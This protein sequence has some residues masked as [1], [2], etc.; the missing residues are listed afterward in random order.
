MIFPLFLYS[1]YPS[2]QESIISP[3]RGE[4]VLG[5]TFVTSVKTTKKSGVFQVHVHWLTQEKLQSFRMTNFR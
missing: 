5:C 4:E 3:R 2:Q 1:K